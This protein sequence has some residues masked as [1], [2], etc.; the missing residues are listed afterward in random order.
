MVE[1]QPRHISS[2]TKNSDAKI[3]ILRKRFEKPVRVARGSA[4]LGKGAAV[5]AMDTARFGSDM[6]TLPLKF[7]GEILRPK[8]MVLSE[9]YPQE[10]YDAIANKANNDGKAV[11]LREITEATSQEKDK[12]EAVVSQFFV[13]YYPNGLPEKRID[14]IVNYYADFDEKDMRH[15]FGASKLGDPASE[16]RRMMCNK[17]SAVLIARDSSKQVVGTAI[18]CD[19]GEEARVGEFAFDCRADVRK[20][21]LGDALRR[22]SL[23]LASSRGIEEVVFD[24]YSGNMASVRSN[25]RINHQPE[26]P[27]EVAI[28]RPHYDMIEGKFTQIAG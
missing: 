21:G 27:W 10:E 5:F 25:L 18:M 1:A 22:D 20:S 2:E 28:G 3:R 14:D 16:V 9:V 23:G 15:R 11:Y 7:A 26:V 17:D 6:A 12:S 4:E 19:I 13:S 8:R 24:I